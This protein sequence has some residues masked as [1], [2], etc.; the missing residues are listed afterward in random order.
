[1][2]LALMVTGEPYYRNLQNLQKCF[3]MKTEESDI[4]NTS[5]FPGS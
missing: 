3:I 5:P 2:S 1:M 4:K